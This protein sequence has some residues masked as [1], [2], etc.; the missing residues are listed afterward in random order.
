[1]TTCLVRTAQ[2]RQKSD[3]CVTPMF[4]FFRFIFSMQ[5]CVFFFTC[6]SESPDLSA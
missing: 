6:L 1:M 5:F 2:G 4:V 3:S